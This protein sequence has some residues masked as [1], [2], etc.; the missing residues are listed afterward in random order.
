MGQMN[1]L[2]IKRHKGKDFIRFPYHLS[3]TFFH[4]F[5]FFEVSCL[6]LSSESCI[7][8]GEEVSLQTYK[9]KEL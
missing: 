7:F 9:R 4:K 2:P 8:K 6:I 1:I 5:I 3:A